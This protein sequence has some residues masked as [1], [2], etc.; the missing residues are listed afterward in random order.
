MSAVLSEMT[1]QVMAERRGRH[2]NRPAYK[3]EGD[4][5]DTLRPWRGT[6]KQFP[7]TK[8]EYSASRCIGCWY[9]MMRQQEPEN[10]EYAILPCAGCGHPTRPERA[11]LVTAP[12]TRRRKDG[13]CFEC[14]PGAVSKASL[15]HTI[16]GLD[17]FMSV[18]RSN[19][20]AVRRRGWA[21]MDVHQLPREEM[22]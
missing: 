16:K 17:H 3:C 22:P 13:K 18:M 21:V 5:G 1:E 9:A 11:P 12:G 4:C 6:V 20:E 10:P 8:M 7:G 14:G 2:K 19:A 15:D